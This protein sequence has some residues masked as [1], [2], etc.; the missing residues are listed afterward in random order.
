[1]IRAGERRDLVECGHVANSLHRP[2]F[3]I[4]LVHPS[5]RTWAAAGPWGTIR[6]AF[7]RGLPS[8]VVEA[9]RCGDP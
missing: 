4:R 5:A 9:A 8:S 1:V 7:T 2:G 6:T 3:A